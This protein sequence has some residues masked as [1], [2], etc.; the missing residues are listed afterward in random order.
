[1]FLDVDEEDQIMEN[2]CENLVAVYSTRF[3]QHNGPIPKSSVW[4]SEVLPELDN[5]RFKTMMRIT[6]FQFS[7]I[8]DLIETNDIFHTT[9]NQFSVATQPAIMLYRIGTY[10][11]GC[12]V[13]KL[14]RL[15]EIGDGAT[16]DRITK[17]VFKVS[18]LNF[19]HP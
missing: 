4:F 14:A 2:L 13:A 1:M 17:R 6:R 12:S 18:L 15:F 9:K 10:G 19:L 16:I 7:I 11:S 8:L 3:L 5:Y